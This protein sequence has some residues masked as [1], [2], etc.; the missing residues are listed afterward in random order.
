M[1]K[2]PTPV[3]SM[4]LLIFYP[5]FQGWTQYLNDIRN[6]VGVRV[7]DVQ[8]A[9]TVTSGEKGFQQTADVL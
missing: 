3:G 9:L 6:R 7:A 4:R 5:M 8:M 1:V 2:T